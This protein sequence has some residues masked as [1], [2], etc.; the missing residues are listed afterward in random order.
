MLGRTF[1]GIISHQ[2]KHWICTLNE[3]THITFCQL[4]FTKFIMSNRAQKRSF[5]IYVII[6]LPLTFHEIAG[7]FYWVRIHTTDIYKTRTN[8]LVLL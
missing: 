5:G 4:H 8:V 1:E 7:E 3:H 6:Y 2:L